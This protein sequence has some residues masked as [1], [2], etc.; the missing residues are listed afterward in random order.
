MPYRSCFLRLALAK[1]T[2]HVSVQAPP[3]HRI[4]IKTEIQVATPTRQAQQKQT[5]R[6]SKS[7]LWIF[8][9]VIL[10]MFQ[11]TT[12]PT[13]RVLLMFQKINVQ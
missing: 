7:L 11:Q 10:S 9:A 12:I 5:I 6:K 13:D 4:P 1:K 2:E 3:H 8:H